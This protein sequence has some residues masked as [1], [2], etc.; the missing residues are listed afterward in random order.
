MDIELDGSGQNILDNVG[1]CNMLHQVLRLEPG[2]GK[3]TAPVCSSWVFLCPGVYVVF[4]QAPTQSLN[5]IPLSTWLW[6]NARHPVAH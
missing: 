1:F 4:P 2:A 3:W 5:L 6:G